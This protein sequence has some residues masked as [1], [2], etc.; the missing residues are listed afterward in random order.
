MKRKPTITQITRHLIQLISFILLP[1]LFIYVFSAIGNIYTSLIGGTFAFEKQWDEI[2]LLGVVLAVTALW[3]RFFCGFLCSFGAM[4]DLLWEIRHFFF[5]KPIKIPAIVDK[6]L[7]YVKYLILVLIFVFIW[8]L[9]VPIDSLWNPWTIF[10][11]YATI[12]G[13]PPIESLLSVG[14]ALLLLIIIGDILIERF[15]CRYLCPLGAVYTLI[16]KFRLFKI[17]KLKDKCGN[18]RLCSTKCSMSIEMYKNDVVKSGECIDCMKCVNVCPRKNITTNCIPALAGTVASVAMIGAYYAGTLKT[19]ESVVISSTT[20]QSATAPSTNSSKYKDGTY[21]GSA[22]GFRGDTQVSVTVANGIITDITLVSK[23]DDATFFD[24][25]WSPIIT[26]IISSQDCNAQTVSGATFSSQSIINAV[27]NALNI[28]EDTTSDSSTSPTETTT[29]PTETQKPQSSSSSTGSISVA[30]G[31]YSG[32][33]SGY[34]GTTTVS[35]T[36]QGGTITDITVESYQ[37]DEQFFSKAK[38]GVID[39][40]L[41]Q[42]S[43]DVSTVSGA[44]F[45]SNSIKEAVSN[46]LEINFSNPN[47]TTQK[48]RKGH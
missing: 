17:R 39:A 19:T 15:F 42:Q 37:D 29:A 4:G 28:T 41:S 27:K 20:S 7:K 18:C 3:G 8:T 34:R 25:A 14:G 31:T 46:A 24:K 23:A 26:N 10:G 35:V 45:S 40:I 9:A 36:V 1:G 44:T 21:T 33:G 30:D 48:S 6:I 11:M 38:S 2:L 16:S 47:S 12:N 5:K 13:F 22:K 43:V 32:S